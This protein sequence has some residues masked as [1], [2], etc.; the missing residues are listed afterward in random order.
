MKFYTDKLCYVLAL[1]FP[2]I[3]QAHPVLDILEIEPSQ[4]SQDFVANKKQFQLHTLITEQRHA[5]TW[6]LS[7]EI[8]N[9]TLMGIQSLLNVDEDISKKITDLAQ[10]TSL[11][12]QAAEAVQRA[13][14]Q[15]QKVYI[16]GCGATGRLAKQ[17][18]SSFW[19]PFWKKIQALPQWEKLKEHFPNIENRLIG[20]MTGG[21][22]ALISSLEGFEDLQLIGELQLA[23]HKIEKGDVIIAVTEGGETSSVIGTV[24]AGLRQYNQNVYDWKTDAKNHLYFVYNN[25]DEVLLPFERSR[26]V[27]ENDAIT[28]ISLFTGP[29]S[30]TGSTRMQATTSETFVVG[31]ILEHAVYQLIQPYLSKEELNGLGF[32]VDNMRERL[33][34]FLPTREAVYNAQTSISQ[35]TDLES[36]TYQNKNTSTYFAQN[37]LITVFIDSTERSPTFRLFPLDT[38]NASPRKSWIQVWTPA[39]DQSKAWENFL[40]RP[41]CGLDRELYEMPFSQRIEDPYLKIAALRSLNNAGNDQQTFYDFSYSPTNVEKFGPKE[42]D[43]GVMVLFESELDQLHDVDSPFHSWLKTF[44]DKQARVAAI[45]MPSVQLSDQAPAREAIRSLCPDAL[46]VQLPLENRQDPMAIR[47]HVALKMLL[48]AHSTGVMAKLGRVVGNTMTNVN[49][50]NL[51]LIG[52]ATFLILS[53]VND[54][55]LESERITY[56][57][58]NAVLF[59]A[60]EYSKQAQKVGQNAEVGLSIIRILE[61]LKNNKPISWSTAEAILENKGLEGY[62]RSQVVKQT[63]TLISK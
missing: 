11:L 48:N 41:F 43:L 18:E 3:A 12:D 15:N 2:L 8:Q 28:K 54:N 38:L 61:S 53:H 10:N 9:N 24:L 40:G 34:S 21:D 25:P 22:R 13:I 20:E 62:L 7:Y 39:Q 30:I 17:M 47:Q 31:V 35:L 26:S 49:P 14:L 46:V 36:T 57:E 23:D 4:Q 6:D 27:L 42:K 1:A 51:K 5:E 63:N 33:L 37:A 60:I 44:A 59:D 58:A 56:E 52:R 16:Y 50:G 19:R 29:Q 55:L 32:H 45:L